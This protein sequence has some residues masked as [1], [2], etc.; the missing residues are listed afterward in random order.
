[1]KPSKPKTATKPKVVQASQAARFLEAARQAR[2]SPTGK[3]FQRTQGK[4]A[5]AKQARK[6]TRIG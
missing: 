1:M 6:A 4:A 3:E 5:L 2:V